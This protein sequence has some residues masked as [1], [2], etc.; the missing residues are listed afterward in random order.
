MSQTSHFICFGAHYGPSDRLPATS[1][2]H[3]T[4]GA[5]PWTCPVVSGLL[6]CGTRLAPSAPPSPL[7]SRVVSA[8]GKRPARYHPEGFYT[9]A[10]SLGGGG[11]G[12]PEGRIIAWGIGMQQPITPKQ[13]FAYDLQEYIHSFLR[14]PC[15]ES[16]L[17]I[18]TWCPL[19]RAQ[20]EPS[21]ILNQLIRG[22]P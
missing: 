8:Y 4:A 3:N 18:R 15:T 1:V 9:G 20:E 17:G 21:S 22:L 5:S 12:L 16:W 14:Q 10:R 19:P 6:A 2:R 7:S 11:G 13:C